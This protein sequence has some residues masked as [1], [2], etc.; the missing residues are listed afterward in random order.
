LRPPSTRSRTT[1]KQRSPI[2]CVKAGANVR[3]GLGRRPLIRPR[4]LV[5][6]AMRMAHRRRR[7]LA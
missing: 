7:I 3:R 5:G 6:A 2:R 1:G 4:R